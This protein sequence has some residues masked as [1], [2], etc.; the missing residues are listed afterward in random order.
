MIGTGLVLVLFLSGCSFLKQP[1][2][3]IQKPKLPD[4]KKI[5]IDIVDQSI[6]AQARLVAPVQSN[7]KG[8]I[9]IV[10]PNHAA[11]TLALFFYETRQQRIH[12]AVIKRGTQHWRKIYDEE[13]D[14]A[15][16]SRVAVTDFGNHG[17]TEIFVSLESYPQNQL[18]VYTLSK[19]QLNKIM[20][21]PFSGMIAGDLDEDHQPDFAILRTDSASGMMRFAFYQVNQ[22]DE[23]V[24]VRQEENVE[25]F[26]FNNMA[27]PFDASSSGG[28]VIRDQTLPAEDDIEKSDFDTKGTLFGNT[29]VFVQW[30]DSALAQYHAGEW[31]NLRWNPFGPNRWSSS[32]M[33]VTER[34][35]DSLRQFFVDFPSGM[36]EKISIAKSYNNHVIFVQANGSIYMDVYRIRKELFR[37]ERYKN[38]IKL[39]SSQHYI[40]AVPNKYRQAAGSVKAGVYNEHS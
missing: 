1:Q 30:G 12:F 16:V 27:G 4:Q 15:G 5:M 31:K 36:A 39:G 40:F 14:A 23:P 22:E 7:Y 2:A 24:L 13:T 3:L 11:G 9:M 20:T 26:F 37:S 33:L 17:S 29:N 28:L 19:G 35:Y 18:N 25:Q 10:K 38:W 21:S 34:Y 6:P 8:K 32:S